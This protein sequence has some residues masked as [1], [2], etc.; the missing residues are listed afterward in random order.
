[1]KNNSH[2]LILIVFMTLS[3]SLWEYDDPS[4]SFGNAP[5]ETYLT[6]IAQDTIWISR[7][8]PEEDSDTSWIFLTSYSDTNSI[9]IDSVEIYDTLFVDSP[10][11]IDTSVVYDTT[12]YTVW[13]TDFN[14]IETFYEAV[15]VFDTSAF[16]TITTSRKDLNWWGED[17]DGDIIGYQYRW[18]G[19][20]GWSIGFRKWDRTS[21]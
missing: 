8:I 11:T 19:D 20:A 15:D 13:G 17:S 4:S 5:P 18:D 16:H 2:I 9:V 10:F 14:G 21:D 3:C 12:F 7:S 1:M 6:L